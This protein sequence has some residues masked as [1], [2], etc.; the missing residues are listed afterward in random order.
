MSRTRTLGRLPRLSPAMAVALLSLFV[1]LSGTAVA[2][3]LITGT[4]IKDGTVRGIDVRND[5]LTG[6]DVKNGTL[7][8]ADLAPAGPWR[9]VSSPGQVGFKSDWSNTA[10][11]T[12][13]NWELVGF[14]KDRDG[15]VHLRGAAGRPAD[16][17]S[18]STIFTLPAGY[19]PAASET[20][21]VASMEPGPAGTLVHGAVEI[22]WDGNVFVY[23]EADDR[24]VTLS[25]IS[26]TATQ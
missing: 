3:T 5:S 23:P 1:A 4:Q 19:R 15:V 25:G 12:G 26:F 20:F 8:A 11:Y 13:Y 18:G 16:A 17:A 10:D 24:L 2:A 14:R 22:D 21:V 6:S 9:D 7:R